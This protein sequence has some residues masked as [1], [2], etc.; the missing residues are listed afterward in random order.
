MSENNGQPTGSPTDPHPY[1]PAG[2]QNNPNPNQPQAPDSGAERDGTYPP[3]QIPPVG[4]SVPPGQ[5]TKVAGAARSAG[6]NLIARIIGVLVVLALVSGGVWLVKELTGT[7]DPKVG[8]CLVMGG[9]ADDAKHKKIT[10]DDHS[11]ISYK[12][13]QVLKGKATCSSENYLPYYTTKKKT[14]ETLET[15]C[16]MP[17][18]EEG[19][20]YKDDGNLVTS[21]ACSEDEAVKIVKRENSGNATCDNA[22]TPLNYPD[23]APGVTYCIGE[24]G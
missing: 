1:Q 21:A 16:L 7:G 14:G 13:A 11:K 18:L 24:A 4:A 5:G 23:P 6:K 9:T 10:C 2:G 22:T 8:D 20:C 15:Y 3:G 12:V 19:K 17:N